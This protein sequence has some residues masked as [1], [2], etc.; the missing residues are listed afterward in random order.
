MGQFRMSPSEYCILSPLAMA[1]ESR[2]R[3]NKVELRESCH[4]DRDIAGT[5]NY[6]SLGDCFSPQ[7][8]YRHNLTA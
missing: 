4:L 2:T 8:W 1:G 5:L 3:A 7:L 6:A